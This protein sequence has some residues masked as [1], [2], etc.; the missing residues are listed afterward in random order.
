MIALF[1]AMTFMEY[2][3]F[4]DEAIIEKGYDMV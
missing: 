2:G 3:Q 1:G 4:I